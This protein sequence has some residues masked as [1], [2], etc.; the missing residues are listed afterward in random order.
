MT[1]RKK[2]KDVS[3]SLLWREDT[4]SHRPEIG[5]GNSREEGPVEA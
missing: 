5:D 2:K 4:P 3:P 1:K